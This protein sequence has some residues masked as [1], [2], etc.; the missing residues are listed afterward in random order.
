MKDIKLFVPGRLGII[1]ETSDLVSQYL[2]L[3]SDLIPGQAISV[4]LNIGIYS[5]VQKSNKLIYEFRDDYFECDI[6]NE[7]L[8][9]EAENNT[10]Y[11]YICGTILYIREKYDVEGIKIEIEKMDLP[12]KKG[13][14]SSAAI[15]ITIAK[16]YN[17]LYSLNLSSDEIKEIAYQGEHIAQS[18]CGRLDQESIMNKKASHLI[19]LG[20]KVISKEIQIKDDVY[21]LIVDLKGNKNTKRIMNAFNAA[22]PFAKNDNDKLIHNIIGK[23]NKYL[24]ESAIDSLENGN[25]EK[26]G[27]ILNE[28]QKLM[29]NAARACIEYKAPILHNVINDKDIQDFIYGAKSIGS[30]G[31]GSVIFVCRDR[32]NQDKLA[33][34]IKKKFDMDSICFNIN[35]EKEE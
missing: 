14:A 10:F 29:D 35:R 3:N 30:G 12:I 15:C 13:L 25:L 21:F 27:Y 7:M 32:E 31:D 17:E 2:S 1:G 28:A 4:P 5:V 23:R 16:A 11:S 18:K 8:R 26:L 34:Y 9:R 24:V 19:F 22:L 6:S 20:N 33:K